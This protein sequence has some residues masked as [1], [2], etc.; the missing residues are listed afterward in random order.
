MTYLYKALPKG[1]GPA[2]LL[3]DIFLSQNS[4]KN[5]VLLSDSTR[6]SVLPRVE[7]GF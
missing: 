5:P 1:A 7:T 3:G 6:D 2:P 4:P